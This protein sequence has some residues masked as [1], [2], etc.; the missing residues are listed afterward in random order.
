M[1]I[2]WSAPCNSALL[3]PDEEKFAIIYSSHVLVIVF[4]GLTAAISGAL[5]LWHSRLDV[6]QTASIWS[7]Y[8]S[9]AKL[10]CIGSLFGCVAWIARMQDTVYGLQ[11]LAMG[12]NDSQSLKYRL[13]SSSR[14]WG[15]A[16]YLLYPVEFF[17]TCLAKLLVLERMV[18]FVSKTLSERQKKLIFIGRRLLVAVVVVGNLVLGGSLAAAA[19]YYMRVA[20]SYS[21]ASNSFDANDVDSALGYLNTT[22][23]S[24]DSGDRALSVQNACESIILISIV[25]VFA[26]CGLLVLRQLRNLIGVIDSVHGS[27]DALA[28][29]GRSLHRKIIA[30]VV[31]V[32]LTFIVRASFA[33][34]LSVGDSAPLDSGCGRCD[35]CQSQ[36]YHSPLHDFFSFLH[37]ITSTSSLS[38][39]SEFH[40][41]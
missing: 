16:F 20:A 38:K 8:G 18:E 24:Y 36:V 25:A 12:D 1:G 22:F 30:T 32:F 13:Y 3:R 35:A 27:H 9:L 31:V 29:F 39:P 40:F 26:L 4:F 21:D 33:V 41:I 6:L 37:V 17:C 2:D 15:S 23:V 10:A 28:N 7:H 11:S 5:C 19:V 14:Y 34:M